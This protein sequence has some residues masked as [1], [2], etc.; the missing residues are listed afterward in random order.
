MILGDLLT[1]FT[2]T[3]GDLRDLEERDLERD[4]G[5]ER[6]LDLERDFDLRGIFC[7]TLTYFS[8]VRV[9]N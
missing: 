8:N 5:E 1:Y 3:L 4:L 6:D 7:F 2:T 9:I